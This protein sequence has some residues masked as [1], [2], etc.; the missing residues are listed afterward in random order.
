LIEFGLL[1]GVAVALWAL[2]V[3][4]VVPSDLAVF[5]GAAHQIWHGA[6]PYVDP[7]SPQLW[8]GHAFVYPY[9]TGW[10]F[11]PFNW[12]TT[13]AATAVFYVLSVAAVV[14][15]VRLIVGRDGAFLPTMVTLL[16]EPVVRGL[17][18]GTL[19]AWLFLGLAVAWRYRDR[20]RRVVVALSAVIVAKLFLVPM[21]AWLVLTRR[22]RTAFTTAGVSLA[23]VVIGCLLAD[24]SVSTFTR[25]LS[26]LSAHE[27]PHSSS[28]EALLHAIGITGALAAIT[29][30]L[31]AGLL[32]A[33]GWRAYRRS[34]G[35]QA[36]FCACVA[37]SIVASPIVWSHYFTLLMVIPLIYRWPARWL[38]AALVASWANGLP[39]GAPAL[40]ALHPFPGAGWVWAGVI[41]LGCVAVQLVDGRRAAR[42]RDVPVSL[43]K[44]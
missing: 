26:T 32:I 2:L 35:E 31:L 21:L 29:P 43:A 24:L 9:L 30:L 11:T 33:G 27:G 34:G 22:Y 17:Q 16:A 44:S 10:L 23:A 39:A 42:R 25:M 4:P 13:P 40:S 37:A 20:A 18:L 38:L 28:I 41:A 19:N 8:S 7:S 6:S 3:R 36:L 15:A 1:A 5:L 14:V 12:M